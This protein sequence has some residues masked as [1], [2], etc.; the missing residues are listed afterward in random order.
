MRI[1]PARRGHHGP[2]T[3][4][5]SRTRFS[6][7]A[8]D[9][10][11]VSLVIVGGDTRPMQA[12][13][14]GW[15]GIEAPVGAGTRYRFLIDDE[16]EVPDP[17]SRAQ[18]GDVHEPSLVVDPASYQWRHADWRGRPW[19]ETVLYELHVGACGGYAG[20]E[21]HL[22]ALA[23]LGVTAIELMPLAEFPGERNWGYDGVLLYAPEASYGSPDDLKHLIDTAHGLGLM[24]FL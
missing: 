11:S 20:V 16:L 1:Q 14:D 12:G 4:D 2:E 3:L 18:A 24:V 19:H 21:Q 17:A 22:A 5:P 8:P 9:A 7:W 15:Y 23:E 13:E 6:L 10:K